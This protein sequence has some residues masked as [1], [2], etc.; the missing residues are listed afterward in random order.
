MLYAPMNGTAISLED[1]GDDVFANRVL[2]DGG[3]IEPSEGK[4]Y[5]PC[6]GRIG[7]VYETKH[8][9]NMESADG[10]EILL[11]IGLE[12]AELQGKHY[13]THVEDGQEVRRG[14]LLISFD[15]DAI[16]DEGYDV[17][18][19]MVICNSGDYGEVSSVAEGEISVGDEFISAE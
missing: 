3:A 15:I 12:T 1:I 2:G 4:L 6:D 8:A 11:Q 17:V 16:K 7:S 19:P 10:E 13:E 9:V 5:S 18:T 14:D